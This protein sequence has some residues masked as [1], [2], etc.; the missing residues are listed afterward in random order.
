MRQK[1][2]SKFIETITYEK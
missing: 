1:Y 2:I